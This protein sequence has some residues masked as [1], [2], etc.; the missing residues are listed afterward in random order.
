MEEQNKLDK[1]ES[2]R[3]ERVNAINFKEFGRSIKNCT[4]EQQSVVVSQIKTSVLLIELTRRLT[5]AESKV[6]AIEKITKA[7]K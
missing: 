5:D 4:D 6:E 2:E 1:M 3:I 7:V